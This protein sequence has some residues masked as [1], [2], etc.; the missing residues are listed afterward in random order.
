MSSLN[1]VIKSKF[2]DEM[3]KMTEFT[4]AIW[5]F[6]VDHI[7]LVT[8]N[9]LIRPPLPFLEYRLCQTRTVYA[10]LIPCEAKLV[11]KMI[12]L[13]EKLVL[14]LSLTFEVNALIW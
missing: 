13:K 4:S 12:R 3:Y 9:L 5:V 10:K 6:N 8:E 11:I 1:H 7:I 2:D 14:K